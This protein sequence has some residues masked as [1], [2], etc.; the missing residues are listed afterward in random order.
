MLVAGIKKKGVQAI[1]GHLLID[2]GLWPEAR[3][4]MKRASLDYPSSKDAS[5]FLTSALS[6]T[7]RL[8]CSPRWVA[9][10]WD[11][12]CL[13]CDRL[14]EAGDHKAITYPTDKCSSPS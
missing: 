5:I 10:R 13:L 14:E 6:L 9:G 4:G 8:H 2:W 11:K 1:R 3:C 12:R 7:T